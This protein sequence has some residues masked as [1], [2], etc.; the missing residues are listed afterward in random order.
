MIKLSKDIA[1]ALLAAAAACH[2]ATAKAEAVKGDGY[3]CHFLKYMEDPGALIESFLDGVATVKQCFALCNS[4]PG[5]VAVTWGEGVT[6]GTQKV[7]P[8]CKLY[9]SAKSMSGKAPAR[10]DGVFSVVNSTVC[11]KSSTPYKFGGPQNFIQIPPIPPTHDRYYQ[12][13]PRPG[14]QPG[15]GPGRQR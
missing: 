12:G 8:Y 13:S 5:C 15:P 14:P 6:I 11:V 9:N 7:P 3:E 4:T 2:V 1:I 10:P